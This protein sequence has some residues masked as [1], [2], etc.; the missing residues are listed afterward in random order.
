MNDIV[1]PLP[2]SLPRYTGQAPEHRP[3]HWLRITQGQ[4]LEPHRV[5][6]QAYN[7]LSAL[8]PAL[9]GQ[10]QNSHVGVQ[11]QVQ[12]DES[13]I[14]AVRAVAI[15]AGLLADEITQT[16]GQAGTRSVF[17]VHCAQ[18]QDASDAGQHTCCQCGVVLEVRRHFSERLGAY[19]GVC[20]DADRPYG[21]ACA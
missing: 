1:A 14:W 16:L 18:V 15:E 20:A 5:N 17:C 3:R 7:D 9:A 10:L 4:G 8:L 2:T 19:I 13:F 21:E 6:G 12:G 11:L